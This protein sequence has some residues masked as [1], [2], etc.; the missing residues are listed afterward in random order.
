MK[1]IA[2]MLALVWLLIAPPALAGESGDAPPPHMLIPS[3]IDH[4]DDKP[5]TFELYVE[6]GAPFDKKKPTV[7]FIADGQQF[8]IRPN[9]VAGQQARFFGDAFNVVG[10]M[11]RGG[12]YKAL[13]E[14]VA[15]A[16]GGTDWRQAWRLYR[17]AQW[18]EDIETVR[19]ALLGDKGR[20]MLFGR[21]GGAYLV[22]EYIAAHGDK[23]SR[24]FTSAPA[25]TPFAVF[26]QATPDHFWEE[27][28]EADPT[29]QQRI[30]ALIARDDVDRDKLAMTFQRQNFFVTADARDAA[31]LDLLKAFEENDRD[32]IETAYRDYQVDAVRELN[33]SEAGV[34]VRVRLFEFAAPFADTWQVRAERLDP[35]IEVLLE[36]AAP[37][38][39]LY[40]QGDIAFDPMNIA[41]LHART[42]TEVFVLAG[43]RDHVVDYRASIALA[44]SYP[45]AT[46]FIAD[47]THVFP[48]LVEAGA[49]N[50]LLQSFLLHGAGSPALQDAMTDAEPLRWR[51]YR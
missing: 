16:S 13:R 32:A 22:H 10:I 12:D 50:A 15:D 8:F 7:F 51:E 21:S 41:A 2:P 31:R 38:M 46:L 28:G 39:M 24:A 26:A 17:S 43:R 18:V 11:G 9:A 23:V 33:A 42:D 5:A 27:I 30:K 19:R 6:F 34:P 47:D 14:R 29:A 44:A 48:K 37:L 49:F 3:Q 40:R 1:T 4:F 45:N 25:A 35:D 36:A 20:I